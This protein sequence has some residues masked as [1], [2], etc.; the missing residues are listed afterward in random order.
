MTMTDPVADLL[1]RIRNAI[2]E[3]HETVAIPASRIKANVVRVLKE[4]GYIKNF[5]L[6]RNENGFPM[7][8]VY[9]KYEVESGSPVIRGLK[10]ISRPGLRSYAGYKEMPRPLSG[11]G[12]AIVSTSRGVLTGQSAKKMKVG[13]EVLC[14]VW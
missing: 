7:I 8:K 9:L 5:R 13:G 10:R 1:T 11:G 2:Q 12:I 3:E 14:E 6:M 4:E